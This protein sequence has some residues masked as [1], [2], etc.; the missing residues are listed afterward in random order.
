MPRKTK[1][2]VETL[3]EEVTAYLAGRINTNEGARQLGLNWQSF[4]DWVRRYESEGIKGLQPKTVNKR[5]GP[6][7]KARAVGGISSR[8]RIA[9]ANLQK[10]CN[11]WPRNAPKVDKSV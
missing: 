6:E 10:I 9:P 4:S 5:Y 2:S 1:L 11:S 8:G 7:L 3:C